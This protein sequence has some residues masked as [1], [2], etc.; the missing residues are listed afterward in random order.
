MKISKLSV[1]RPVTTIMMILIIIVL[2]TVS[3]SRLSIDLLPKIEVPVA[4]VSTSY[5][6]V[7]PEEVEK[8]VTKPIEQAVATVEGI[9]NVSSMNSEGNSVVIAEFNFGTDMEFA[10]LHMREKIDMIKGYLPE[11]TNDPMVLKID[12]N[13]QAVMI[14]S[15]TGYKELSQLQAFVEDNIENKLERSEGV[16]SVNINGGVEEQIEIKINEEKLHGYGISIEYISQIL[17]GENLNLPSGE[18][19]KGNQELLIRTVGEFKSIDDIKEVPIPLKTGGVVYLK[20]ISTITRNTKEITEIATTN[21]KNCL[22]LSI[23][24]QS[25]AN[26][27]EVSKNLIKEIEKLKKVYPNVKINILVD[28][29]EYINKS[30][31]NVSNTAIQGGILAVIVLLI[32][33]R[34]I[35][36]TLIIGTA[37]PV[38][39]IGT[40]AL[41]YS[42]DITLNLMTLGGLAL[43][44]G[45]LVDNSIVVLEN[46]YRFIQEGYPV[47]QAAIEGASEVTMSVVASTLTTVAVFLPIAFTNGITG[48]MFK[49][50][51]MTV[52]FSIVASLVVAL[53]LIPMLSS[54]LL[55][56][57]QIVEGVDVVRKK[58]PFGKIADIF[59]RGFLAVEMRYKKILNWS[60]GHRKSTVIIGILVFV[61][62]MASLTKVGAEFFPSND[63][64]E[65]TI[66]INLPN[67]ASL[68]DTNKIVDKVEKTL[69]KADEVDTIFTQIGGSSN[70]I[71]KA[72]TNKA[73]L[74]VK[75]VSIKSRDRSVKDI[76][77]Q[78]RKETKDIPGAEIKFSSNS[79]MGMGA[80]SAPVSIE[81]KGDNLETLR[82]L[83]EQFKKVVASVEGTRQVESSFGDGNPEVRIKINRKNASQYGLTA[84]QIAN[85]VNSIISGKK[86]TTY[87]LDNGDEIDVVVKG[88][89]IYRQS[90]SNLENVNVETQTGINIPLNL[91]ADLEI[92]RGPSSINRDS[93]TRLVTVTSQLYGRDLKSVMKDVNANISKINM[94]EGYS[95]KIGGENE[96]MM[97]AFNDLLLALILAVVLVYMIL[98][99]QFESLLNP[100][101]IMFSVPLAVAGGALG[102]FITRRPLSVP[103]FI[104]VIVLAGIVVNNAIVLIDYINIRRSKGEGRKEAILAA[105]PTRL[106]PILMT[107]STTILG[108]LP[109]ALGLGEGGETQ[110]P[111]A[112]VVIG[113][114]LFSTVL[115]LIF[116]PVIYT[117][118]DDL[119]NKVGKKKVDKSL[120]V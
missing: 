71:T 113:G 10:T 57:E 4:V 102:L 36:S 15:V 33:L 27:V 30:I 5:P 44:I 66:N 42:N 32:F 87:K 89:D 112:T 23:K 84:G 11:D 50:L 54:K 26:T 19:D 64:G 29:A 90:I 98:A 40:F 95:Y 63:M 20:D 88:D 35:R 13:A 76:M 68:A 75:L 70:G 21:G 77:D 96:D 3:L 107:A 47:K 100:F 79:G 25:D 97:E 65:F 118:F 74:D 101:V 119:R 34:N 12:P 38:S 62:S 72:G 24:K 14:L 106:R 58:G 116:I 67:G 16:A 60:L 8:L 103:A 111:M 45:M 78:T 105:G 82:K 114:L 49:E 81:I 43:G 6:N 37:I 120:A 1:K 73:S 52:V 22:S 46:I 92:K 110:A 115:T 86:A 7:G 55:K 69:R 108:L 39:I 9:K 93:Q 59:E 48:M 18:V 109:M 17:R 61:I 51:A 117:L 56:E 94:P 28:Q 2:G 41:L 53:T 83:G 99:S 85:Q 80:S 31:S 91:V 104:G